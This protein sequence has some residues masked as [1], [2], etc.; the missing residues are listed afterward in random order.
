MLRGTAV[1]AP[2]PGTRQ[3]VTIVTCSESPGHLAP[4]LTPLA[5]PEIP[6]YR[7]RSTEQK[8]DWVEVTGYLLRCLLG[9]LPQDA[10]TQHP[11]QR[12]VTGFQKD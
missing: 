2:G 3:Q 6:F 1:T 8:Q 11:S 12:E 5:K 4:I 9:L 7:G 10:G